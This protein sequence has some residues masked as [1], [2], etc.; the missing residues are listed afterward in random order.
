MRTTKSLTTEILKQSLRLELNHHIEDFLR[1]GGR[2]EVVDEVGEAGANTRP[3]RRPAAAD[4][5]S[6][7]VA[8]TF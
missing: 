5:L 3:G 8:D 4:L 2:I 6:L 7:P 1:K